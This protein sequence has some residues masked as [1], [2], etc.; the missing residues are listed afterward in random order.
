MQPAI[1]EEPKEESTAISPASDLINLVSDDEDDMTHPEPT[2]PP[3]R[4]ASPF[5]ETAAP[6]TMSAPVNLGHSL[7]SAAPTNDLPGNQTNK[8]K[9]VS[10]AT[11]QKLLD[12]QKEL[13]QKMKKPTSA[14][15][16][17]VAQTPTN[18]PLGAISTATSP[19]FVSQGTGDDTPATETP[20]QPTDDPAKR[21][22]ALKRAADKKRKNGT[23]TMEEEIEFLRAQNDEKARVQRERLEKSFNDMTTPEPEEEPGLEDDYVLNLR[24]D[25]PGFEMSEDD[26]PEEPKKKGGRKRKAPEEQQSGPPKKRGRPTKAPKKAP[27]KDILE[28]VREK[29]AAKTAQG[30]K[31]GGSKSAATK[32]KGKGKKYEGPNKITSMFGSNVFDD[33]E[34]NSGVALPP[35]FE[36]T[37]R[38]SKAL[39]SLIADI[40]RESK[41]TAQIDK[42]YLN[43]AMKSFTD[44]RSIAPAEDGNWSLKGLKVTLKHYQVLGVAFMRNRENSSKQP[45]G[46]ILAD[47]MGLG[48]TI[49]MLANIVNGKALVGP[50]KCKTTLIVAS[51]ALIT[52]WRQEIADK[53]LTV[54]ENKKHGLGRVKEYSSRAQLRSNEEQQELEEVSS[55]RSILSRSGLSKMSKAAVW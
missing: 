34:R 1:K 4:L 18:Q 27:E 49:Q 31:K 33:T 12:R 47:E 55:K 30:R 45:K 28:L 46:G 24:D 42:R 51:P 3:R 13:A 7:F 32:S 41:K 11:R 16:T 37:T 35:T 36:A 15:P 19:L 39:S 53:V 22:A 50:K 2:H 5:Q 25:V 10:D 44:P 21:F 8:P 6:P 26:E 38:R 48:K 54:H 40:P 20:A 14:A 17:P 29:Q 52:Q 43:D 23:F 9:G